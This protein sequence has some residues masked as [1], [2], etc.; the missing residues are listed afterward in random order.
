MYCP[1][2]G[3]AAAAGQ[4]FC[5]KCGGQLAHNGASAVPPSAPPPLPARP[6]GPPP[7][8]PSMS[9]APATNAAT[10]TYSGFWR[11]AFAWLLDCVIIYVAAAVVA[12]L[13]GVIATRVS[14]N[15]L[16]L[17]AREL[18]IVALL[19]SPW[20]YYAIMES[21]ALQATVGKLAVGVKVTDLEGKRIT[22]LRATGREFAK[23][24]SG[25]TL[26]VGYALVVFSSQRQALHDMIAGTL[27]AH[28]KL[29][30]QTIASAG[31]APRVS[32]WLASLAVL[33]I[34]FFG[35]FGIGI[36]AAIAIP[37]YQ[38]Y[39]IRAQV[40]EG[41]EAAAPYKVAIAESGAQGLR[42]SDLTTEQLQLP[43]TGQWRYVS[44]IRVVSGI[45]AVTY[46]ASANQ[47]IAGKTVLL[48]PGTDGGDIVWTCG[49]HA[50]P[51]GSTPVTSSDLSAYT[52]LADKYLPTACKPSL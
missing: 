24:L 1:N 40:T 46:G 33:G 18:V 30:E 20:L 17:G 15:S 34:V 6:T 49:H 48:I 32:P 44:S 23:I 27:V 50:L 11:R 8:P 13:V 5:A 19:F 22:F 31:P 26:G 39:T 16:G 35:P 38:D 43:E 10:S 14:G 21:S 2:C 9:S 51:S 3:T 36:L 52:T 42:I 4:N 29:S 41:L 12:L 37:A 7:S 25:M 28:R 47:L 45:V